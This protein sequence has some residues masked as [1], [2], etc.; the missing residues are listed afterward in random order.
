MSYETTQL[1]RSPLLLLDYADRQGMNR[2]ELMRQANISPSSLVDPDSRIPSRAMRKLWAAVIEQTA[3]PVLG[4]R[5]GRAIHASQVGLVGYTMNF[6]NTLGEALNR[7]VR[8]AKIINEAVQYRWVPVEHGRRLSCTMHPLLLAQRHPVEAGM[9]AIVS[10]AR[11]ITGSSVAPLVVEISTPQPDSVR[12]YTNT[13]GGPVVFDR[14]EAA[15]VFGTQQLDL[16]T[17]KSDSSLTG[18]LDDLAAVKL[19]ALDKADAGLVDQVRHVLWP[20]LHGGRPDLW[21]TASELG[22]S[23]RTLQRRLGENGTSFSTVLDELRRELSDELLGGRKLAVA[24]VAFLLGY[25]DPSA[26]QRAFR[27]WRGVSPRRFHSA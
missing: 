15:L 12:E 16:P 8:Y 24:E 3:D 10:I 18:Y 1:A 6:S 21:R 27:R 20:L 25:S 23:A 26:F 13:F 7:F 2:D 11:E 19:A 5:V 4:L 9:A 22:M 14:S 17:V